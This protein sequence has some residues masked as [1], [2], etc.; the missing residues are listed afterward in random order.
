MQ[1]DRQHANARASARLAAALH[2][3]PGRL[4][5][6]RARLEGDLAYPEPNQASGSVASLAHA[7]ALVL[8]PAE[9]EG[10]AAG[11]LVSIIR[12]PKP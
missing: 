12:L 8:V 5:L 7:D 11:E 6:Y 4:G 9:S 1:S 2:Q 10:Y 3:K